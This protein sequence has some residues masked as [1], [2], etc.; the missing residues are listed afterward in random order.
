MNVNNLESKIKILE[1]RIEALELQFIEVQKS[2][3]KIL[4]RFKEMA[5]EPSSL[6][7]N[8][9]EK[10]NFFKAKKILLEHPFIRQFKSEYTNFWLDKDKINKYLGDTVYVENHFNIVEALSRLFTAGI[11]LGDISASDSIYVAWQLAIK[12]ICRK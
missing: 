3:V 11:K 2:A 7:D 10:L 12:E 6:K 1:S 9:P 4:D 5:N 8:L